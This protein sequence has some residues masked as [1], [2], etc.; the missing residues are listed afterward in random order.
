MERWNENDA[1]SGLEIKTNRA[2]SYIDIGACVLYICFILVMRKR[3]G[4]VL[5]RLCGLCAAS[6]TAW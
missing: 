4:L 5:R 3:I 2:L 6:G 1:Y